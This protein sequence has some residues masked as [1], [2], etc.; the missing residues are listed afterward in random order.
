[1]IASVLIGSGDGIVHKAGCHVRFKDTLLPVIASPT[2]NYLPVD[3]TA[4]ADCIRPNDEV[5]LF[6][7]VYT[8][9]KLAVDAG[10]E[11]GADVLIRLNSFAFS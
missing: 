7:T 8:P 5:N 1:M 3:A 11:V 6:D 4:V 10:M 9:D 2:T